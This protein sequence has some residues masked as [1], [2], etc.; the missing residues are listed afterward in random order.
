MV[1]CKVTVHIKIVPDSYLQVFNLS[2]VLISRRLSG[3]LVAGCNSFSE[4]F[5]CICDGSPRYSK[6]PEMQIEL[7]QFSIRLYGK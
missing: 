7:V 3:D 6:W 5:Q 2:L 4:L 1:F